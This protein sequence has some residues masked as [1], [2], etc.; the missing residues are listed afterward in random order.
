M[1]AGG[2]FESQVLPPG[3]WLWNQLSGAD[4]RMRKQQLSEDTQ[5]IQ[6]LLLEECVSVEERRPAAGG[7]A[8]FGCRV[9]VLFKG[10]FSESERR[11]FERASIAV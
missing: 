9:V 1:P 3:W 7:G 10:A 6:S 5:R 2:L 8:V 4:G 11:F